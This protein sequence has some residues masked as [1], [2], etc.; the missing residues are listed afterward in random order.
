MFLLSLNKDG[1]RTWYH[2]GM[3]IVIAGGS[4]FIGTELS[5]ALL[6]KGHTVIVIDIKGPTL[7]HERLFYI[8][9]NLETNTLPFNVLERTDAIINLAGISI[10]GK[11]TAAFKD[12][13]YRSR[14]QATKNLVESLKQT[15]TK[16]SIFIS[17]SASGYYGASEE[18]LNERSPKGNTFLSDV[19][20]AWE[21]EALQAEHLGSRV[22]IVRTAPVFGKKGFLYPLWK[23]SRF[24]I[25][26]SVY[27][28]NFSMSW[29]HI[30]DIVRIYIFAL[31]TNTL[32]G[33]VNAVAPIGIEHKTL[34]KIIA[35]ETK[36]LRVGTLPFGKIFFGALLEET[37][38]T[39]NITPQRLLDK[40]F[41]FAFTD[42]KEAIK[43]IHHAKS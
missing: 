35:K 21:K 8:P 16:P 12:A 32:Q 25:L 43:A 20:D 26:T 19:V 13:I 38:I 42:V 15:A 24:H 33:V 28:R 10:A 37:G 23:M 1:T 27:K 9:C 18:V 39:Q 4:G 36:S 22:V 34:L 30:N 2:G 29:I 5:K 31:E 6:S 11:W 7:T 14:V 17:A 41:E 3:T 40:G